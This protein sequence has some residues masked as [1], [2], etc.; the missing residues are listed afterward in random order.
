MEK[1]RVAGYENH[2]DGRCRLRSYS[3]LALEA[4][5]ALKLPVQPIPLSWRS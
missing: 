4:I 3:C 5:G 1:S 2:I